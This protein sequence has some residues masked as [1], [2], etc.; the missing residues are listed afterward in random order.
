MTGENVKACHGPK[1]LD[2]RTS[3]VRV[4]PVGTVF[5]LKGAVLGDE[6]AMG[7]ATPNEVD[8]AGIAEGLSGG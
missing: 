8:T 5:R 4:I 2:L 3:L 6:R 7:R 1:G